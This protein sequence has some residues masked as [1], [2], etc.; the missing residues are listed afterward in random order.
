MASGAIHWLTFFMVIY[1]CIFI[2]YIVETTTRQAFEMIRSPGLDG[3]QA[4]L[5]RQVLSV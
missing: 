1:Y 4:R 5:I 2:Q 3:Q